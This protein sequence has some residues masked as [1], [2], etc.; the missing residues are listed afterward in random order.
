MS[1]TL[2][3]TQTL[4]GRSGATHMARILGSAGTPITQATLSAIAAQVKDLDY[5][6]VSYGPTALTISTTVFDSLVQ[7]DPRWTLDAKGYNFLWTAPAL[8]LSIAGQRARADVK[9]TPVSGEV[10]VVPF[11]Y[12][13]VPVYIP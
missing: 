1:A 13:L 2:V 3:V 11:E 12:N 8:A 6:S 5:G 10:F 7:N 4:I 9:F